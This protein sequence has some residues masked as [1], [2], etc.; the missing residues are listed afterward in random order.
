MVEAL[1]EART[2]VCLPGRAERTRHHDRTPAGSDS[3]LSVPV[4]EVWAGVLCAPI[5]GVLD[6][7]RAADVTSTLLTAVVEKK[8]RHVIMDVT[9]IEVMDTRCT[10]HFPADCAG[11]DAARRPLLTLRDA[12][13]RRPDDRT[14]GVDLRGLQSY[15]TMREALKHYVTDRSLR[16]EEDA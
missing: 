11:G 14:M 1:S 9:G 8:A 6:S 7:T 5:V 3:D 12:S 4:I 16:T 15:R 10:D 13:E 2:R